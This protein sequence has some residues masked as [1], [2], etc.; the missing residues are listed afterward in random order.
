MANVN[1]SKS[2]RSNN[3]GTTEKVL[4]IRRVNKVVKGGKRLAFRATVVVGDMNGGVGVGVG[5]ASEVPSA[6]RKAIDKAKKS[7]ARVK[8]VGETIP[9][10]V[11]GKFCASEIV[12]KP[13]PRGT[14]VIAGGATRIILELAG[15]KNVVAKSKGSSN[16]INCARATLNG[17]TNLK[18]A[19]D[20][21]NKRGKGFTI[22]YRGSDQPVLVSPQQDN[23]G[24]AEADRD[25]KASAG[26]ADKKNDRK[27]A[28]SSGEVKE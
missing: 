14:G 2:R 22:K 16:V 24:S 18:E 26:A 1:T 28:V 4:Q 6:I 3:E 27:P 8:L 19:Q 21:A 12:M 25:S 17:L 10:Q 20:M 23:G 11:T 15:I 9:H 5:K 13:A 7:L